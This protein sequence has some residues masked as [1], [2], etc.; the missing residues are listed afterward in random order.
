MRGGNILVQEGLFLGEVTNNV[1]EYRG[2]KL[3]LERALEL[4]AR[5]VTLLADS[6]LLIRQLEGSYRVKHPRLRELFAEVLRLRD[7]FASLRLVHI[8]REENREADEMANR[9]IDERL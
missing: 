3:G 2:A 9:A 4:G 8:P 6:Q 5:R 1:A 7:R